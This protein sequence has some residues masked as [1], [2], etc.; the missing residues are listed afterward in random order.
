[1]LSIYSHVICLIGNEVSISRDCGLWVP[2][3]R[4]CFDGPWRTL[5]PLST[6]K[7]SVYLISSLP[8]SPLLPH[9]LRSPHLTAARN[10]RC[11]GYRL[12][13]APNPPAQA[14]GCRQEPTD[15]QAGVQRREDLASHTARGPAGRQVTG[16]APH[17]PFLLLICIIITAEDKGRLP[18][19]THPTDFQQGSTP[20]L[21]HS[22]NLQGAFSWSDKPC[23]MTPL[24]LHRKPGTEGC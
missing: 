17:R 1:M 8:S 4:A 20:G 23:G 5:N 11:Q 18:G 6:G 15:P 19:R 24:Q 22:Q 21:S 7:F 9:R 10:N 16:H 12:Q 14:P 2:L 13:D 3:A